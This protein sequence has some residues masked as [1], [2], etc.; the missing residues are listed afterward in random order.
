MDHNAEQLTEEHFLKCQQ[1][2]FIIEH[3]LTMEVFAFIADD[4][5]KKW[6][7]ERDPDTREALWYQFQNLDAVLVSFQALA[8]TKKMV[9]NKNPDV[10]DEDTALD[11]T[12]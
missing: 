9:D 7:L 8:A 12:E 10:E 5:K 11:K 4:L 6:A 3:P 2:E 1:A